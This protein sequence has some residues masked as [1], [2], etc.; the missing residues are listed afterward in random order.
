[1]IK[2]TGISGKKT[3]VISNVL[4]LLETFNLATLTSSFLETKFDSKL[5]G[6]LCPLLKFFIHNLVKLFYLY[7]HNF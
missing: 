1:M 5:L 6:L 7:Y 3:P 2:F 4:M